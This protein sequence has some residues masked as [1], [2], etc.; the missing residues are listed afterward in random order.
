MIMIKI[1]GKDYTVQENSTILQA[2][3]AARGAHAWTGGARLTAPP[4]VH[5]PRG[6]QERHRA[7]RGAVAWGPS[8]P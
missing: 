8:T 7:L 5:A 3:A 1:D 2:A 4:P 6:A